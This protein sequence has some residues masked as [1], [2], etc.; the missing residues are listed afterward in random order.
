MFDIYKFHS[1]TLSVFIFLLS[2][3]D[4]NWVT[5]FIQLS[6]LLNF[7]DF[8]VESWWSSDWLTIIGIHVDGCARHHTND[9]GIK[10][11]KEHGGI[12]EAENSDENCH[13]DWSGKFIIASSSFH[14]DSCEPDIEEANGKLTQKD[15]NLSNLISEV[16]LFLM[17]VLEHVVVGS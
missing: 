12:G 7:S 4:T 10:D 2:F 3:L 17:L 14:G 9:S 8:L 16:K 6:L 5:F 15:E 11:A 13:D 1:Y